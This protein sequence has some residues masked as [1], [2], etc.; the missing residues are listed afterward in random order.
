MRSRR[1]PSGEAAVWV[2]R[3]ADGVGSAQ[4]LAWPS[5]TVRS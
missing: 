4:P 5:I 3:A 2:G 1:T